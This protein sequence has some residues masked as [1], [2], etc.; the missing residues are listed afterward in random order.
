MEEQNG[1]LS[2]ESLTGTYCW[3]AVGA[4]LTS[5]SSDAVDFRSVPTLPPGCWR[6]VSGKLEVLGSEFTMVSWVGVASSSSAHRESG[7]VSEMGSCA[8]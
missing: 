6:Q 4:F 2:S 7:L 1:V 5:S 8:R 3:D